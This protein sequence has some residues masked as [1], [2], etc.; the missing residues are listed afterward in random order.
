MTSSYPTIDLEARITELEKQV[1]QQKQTIWLLGTV[2][3]V[4]HSSPFGSALDRFFEGND[5]FAFPDPLACPVACSK[6]YAADMA[7]ANGNEA[8]EEAALDRFTACHTDCAMKE[9]SG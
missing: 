4:S 8:A 6:A 5:L 9:A 3:K 2:A 1:S 7:A